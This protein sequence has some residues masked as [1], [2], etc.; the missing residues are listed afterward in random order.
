M[1]CYGIFWSGQLLIAEPPRAQ[2]R[3]RGAPYLR[4]NGIRPR[5][6]GYEVTVRP[7]VLTLRVRVRRN[8]FLPSHLASC[9]P[10]CFKRV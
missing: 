8:E 9:V 2:R 5:K 3:E 7:S 6:F 10:Y 4:E 1:V